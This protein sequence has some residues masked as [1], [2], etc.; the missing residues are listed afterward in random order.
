MDKIV[1]DFGIH[2]FIKSYH[3]FE[4][5]PLEYVDGKVWVSNPF[6]ELED[7]S[8]QWNLR[9]LSQK[10]GKISDPLLERYFLSGYSK[11]L[12]TLVNN[13][14]PIDGKYFFYIGSKSWGE[15]S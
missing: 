11:R 8:K 6:E 14:R 10:C 9:T 13:F 1:L 15:V 5:L 3:V 4:T 12:L 7:G 2:L